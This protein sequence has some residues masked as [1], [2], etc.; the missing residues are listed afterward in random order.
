M[1]ALG[2]GDV[3][4]D[5]ELAGTGG[6]SYR[7]AEER[8]APVVLVFYPADNT[9]VCTAQLTT[10]S[11]DLDAFTTLGARLL[12][13][14]PQDVSSHESFAADHGFAFPL[15][16]DTDKEVGRTYGVLGPLGFYRRS[17]FV[18]DAV[19]VVRYAR[20]SVGGLGFRPTAELVG[21]VRAAT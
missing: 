17:A 20:R 14:S 2:V 3:A 6:R 12:A 9:P 4:P 18:V 7:L 19:G 10:Y 15:L 8:G 5:F 11:H 21:A 1:V 13:I 16:S